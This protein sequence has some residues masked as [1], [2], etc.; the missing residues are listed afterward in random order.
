MTWLTACTDINV[1]PH[2]IG[3]VVGLAVGCAIVWWL[4]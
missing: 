2:I 3:S 4:Y 1:V